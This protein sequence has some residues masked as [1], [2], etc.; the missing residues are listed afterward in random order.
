M[1][2]IPFQGK[3]IN[4]EDAPTWW[5]KHIAESWKEDTPRNKEIC[6]AADQE[7]SERISGK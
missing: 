6:I 7:Y 3:W 4:P 5:L 2:K 1:V